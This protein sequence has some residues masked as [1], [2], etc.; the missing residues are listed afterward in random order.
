LQNASETDKIDLMFR[1]IQYIERQ[2][3]LFDAIEDAAFP[4]V[5]NME[6]IGSLRD[7]KEKADA[8]DNEEEL[9]DFL[10]ILMLGPY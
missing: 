9:I 10:K 4:V 7:I 8:K 1:F 2:I 6:G 5:N 3:V